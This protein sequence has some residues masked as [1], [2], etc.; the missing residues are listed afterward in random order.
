M[1]LKISGLR[2]KHDDESSCVFTTHIF[3]KYILWHIP[4]CSPKL[5]TFFF[6]CLTFEYFRIKVEPSLNFHLIHL[7]RHRTSVSGTVGDTFVFL[8]K[9]PRTK[10]FHYWLIQIFSKII[11]FKMKDDVE[12]SSKN[13]KHHKTT[14]CFY[15]STYHVVALNYLQFLY[16]PS[17]TLNLISVTFHLSFCFC[18]SNLV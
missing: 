2:K 11:F 14:T 10:K 4:S 13:H 17:F 7:N 18:I 16:I 12:V 5:Y 3:W 9:Y 8:N 15:I 1:T 6:L